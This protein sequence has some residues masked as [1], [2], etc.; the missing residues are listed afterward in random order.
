MIKKLLFAA[1]LVLAAGAA[2]ASPASASD[3]GNRQR[4]E[5]TQVSYANGHDRD[6]RYGHEANRLRDS[7][8][9][10]KDCSHHRYGKNSHERDRHD[11]D[12]HRD[13]R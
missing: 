7:H 6:A 13:R 3:W 5:V 11:R 2:L 8:R 4:S 10:R 1:P 9:D 12:N